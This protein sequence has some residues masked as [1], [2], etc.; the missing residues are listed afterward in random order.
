LIDA[1][2]ENKKVDQSFF[3]HV[4]LAGFAGGKFGQF[5]CCFQVTERRGIFFCHNDDVISR[6]KQIFIAAEEFPKKSFYSISENSVAC[7]FGYGDAQAFDSH[8]VAACYHGKEPRTFPDPL[9]VNIPIPALVGN[10]FRSSVRL[11]F[12]AKHPLFQR[13][14][15]IAILNS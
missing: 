11:R 9:F 1:Y 4:L 14:D 13:D 5:S 3:E 7:L 15:I 8:R 6:G 2:Y 12:H 10:L